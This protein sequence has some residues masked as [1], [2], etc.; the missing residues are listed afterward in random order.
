VAAEEELEALVGRERPELLGRG[1]VGG[2]DR[3]AALQERA[4]RREARLRETEDGRAR[5]L[6]KVGAEGEAHR[7]TAPRRRSSSASASRATSRSS[8]GSFRPAVTW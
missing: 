3:D 7:V 2:D 6:G 4:R 5:D 1:R 8:N